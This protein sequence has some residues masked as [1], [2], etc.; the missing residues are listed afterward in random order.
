M[1]GAPKPY[2]LIFTI[3]RETGMRV[4]EVLAL[5]LGDVLLEPGRE[6]LRVREPKNGSERI[7]PLGA[8]IVELGPCNQTIHQI[9]ECVNVDEL[10]KLTL[11]YEKLL[12]NLLS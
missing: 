1:P 3:L 7:A 9:D 10:E 4:G 5:N 2:R 6:G 11:I 8:Q 12:E